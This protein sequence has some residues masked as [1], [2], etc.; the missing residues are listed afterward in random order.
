MLPG[1]PA[2]QAIDNVAH[3]IQVALTPV[4]LL[5]GIGTL[6]NVFNTRLSRV[7]DHRDHA[8]DLLHGEGDAAASAR[9]GAQLRRLQL[10]TVF[11]D[12][13]VVFGAVGAAF[14]CGAALALFLGDLRG[15]DAGTW[16]FLLFGVA[17]G[18]TVAALLAFLID[19]V[20]AWHPS[21][22]AAGVPQEV[23]SVER[24]PPLGQE[25]YCAGHPTRSEF[26]S[27]LKCLSALLFATRLV[28]AGG[29]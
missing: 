1:L 22:R 18:C 26:L 9:L 29:R 13:S 10:R 27:S 17:L 6:L 5:S 21:R 20:L 25:F 16:L 23:L 12:A 3:I 7:S 11:L 4:F 8:Y 28:S 19:S 2:G 14:T 15:A 24:M